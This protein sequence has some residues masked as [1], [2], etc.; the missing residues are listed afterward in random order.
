MARTGTAMTDAG[1]LNMRNAPFKDDFRPIDENCD[2]PACRHYS[3]AYIRHLVMCNEMF[4]LRL[5]A[6]HNIRWT[7][8]FTRRIAE[9][10]KSDTFRAFKQNFLLQYK[11]SCDTVE[12]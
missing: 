4:G 6:L 11:K 5:L 10:I 8:N 12:P 3:R 9:A 7:V 1:N 2:C